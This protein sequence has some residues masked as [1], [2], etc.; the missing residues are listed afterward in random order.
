MAGTRT[1]GCVLSSY[2]E[3]SSELATR[4]AEMSRTWATPSTVYTGH[5]ETR[6]HDALVSRLEEH[7]VRDAAVSSWIG[8]SS[9]LSVFFMSGGVDRVAE[10]GRRNG[11]S[12]AVPSVSSLPPESQDVCIP[13]SSTPGSQG[14]EVV[15]CC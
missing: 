1:K 9:S 4:D 7:N 3:P 14:P 6:G 15:Q 5:G 2:H 10:F 12:S 11:V 13:V 8:F